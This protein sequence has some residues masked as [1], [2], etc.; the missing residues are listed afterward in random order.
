[1][2]KRKWV[3]PFLNEENDYLISDAKNFD[4]IYLE[5]GMGM[6][7][8]I[9]NSANINKDNF[10]IG[11][12]KDATCVARAIKKA[13]ELNITNLKIIKTDASSILDIFNPKSINTIYLHFSDPWPKKHHHK[14][15]LTYPS[16]LKKYETLLKDDGVIVIKTDNI[17][18]FTDTLEYIKLSNFKIL[19]V[20]DNYH[21][22]KRTEPLT[23]Y[24]DKFVKQGLPIYY[25]R[26][27]K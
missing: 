10:Y 19:E 25:I 15:R 23:A 6:G 9:C 24:E 8:F 18:L 1:M 22:I 21:K 7:D 20:N 26:L 13:K 17:N 11:L 5:I 12:E 2:R 3:E 27:S 14:R 16:F 4:N